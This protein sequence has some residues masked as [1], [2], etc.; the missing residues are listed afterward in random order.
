MGALGV[1]L[2]VWIPQFG[3]LIMTAIAALGLVL[4]LRRAY[5]QDKRFWILML[6]FALAQTPTLYLLMP[7]LRGPNFIA[8]FLVCVC[9]V[10]VM[11]WVAILLF[12]V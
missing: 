10:F 5:W 3:F 4:L 12:K 9:D 6:A 7:W 2:E 8:I 1:L 11:N